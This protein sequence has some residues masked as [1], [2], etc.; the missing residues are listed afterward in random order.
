M[1][2]IT[3]VD[4]KALVKKVYE[5]SSPQGMGFLHFEVEPLSDEEALSLIDDKRGIEMDYIKGRACKFSAKYRDGKLVI[6]DSWYDH[7]GAQFQE[8]LNAFGL[9]VP[10][11]KE[12]GCACNCADCRE[13][14]AKKS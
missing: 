4:L 12:H 5:L 8:L 7:S 2:D 9:K 11:K 1:I 10:G 14:R 6:S 13:I 3:G